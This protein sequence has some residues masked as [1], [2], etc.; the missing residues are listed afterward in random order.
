ME[1]GIGIGKDREL[2][3]LN[4]ILSQ[5]ITYFSFVSRKLGVIF[6]QVA[7]VHFAVE[8]GITRPFFQLCCKVGVAF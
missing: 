4:F 6:P 3:P 5:K 1:M 7:L 2:N 8:W